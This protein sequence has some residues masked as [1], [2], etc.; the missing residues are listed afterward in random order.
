MR[1]ALLGCK[2]GPPHWL[3]LA[4]FLPRCGTTVMQSVVPE[5]MVLEDPD[6][7][8]ITEISY[9]I[10]PD[11]VGIGRNGQ[12]EETAQALAAFLTGSEGAGD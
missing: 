11:A 7:E 2:G 10:E 4:S 9:A 8:H 6:V 3:W 5:A 12:H 1:I